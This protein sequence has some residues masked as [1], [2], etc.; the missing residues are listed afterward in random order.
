MVHLPVFAS[1][2]K[3]HWLKNKMNNLNIPSPNILRH[4]NTLYIGNVVFYYIL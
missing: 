1:R 2:I 4:V 3:S